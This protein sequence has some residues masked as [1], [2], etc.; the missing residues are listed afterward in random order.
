MRRARACAPSTRS[1][2]RT[3]RR[4]ARVLRARFERMNRV[5]G[6][7]CSSRWWAGT[8][9]RRLLPWGLQDVELAGDVLE[10]GP[11][12]GATTRVL[13]RRAGSL[14]VL[15]LNRAYAERL[16][17]RLGATVRVVEGDATAMPFED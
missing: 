3:S 15:E 4:F 17:A 1:G 16:R 7:I 6:L 14:T 2:R 5:H 13:T 11:G 12:F 10:I 8:V 9:E